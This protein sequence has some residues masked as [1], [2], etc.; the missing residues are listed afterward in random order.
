MTVMREKASVPTEPGWGD[1]AR[2]WS[3]GLAA[4]ACILESKALSTETRVADLQ[5]RLESR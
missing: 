2:M 3:Y 5:K 4:D 1:S